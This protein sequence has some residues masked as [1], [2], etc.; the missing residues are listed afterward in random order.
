MG[1][2][3]KEDSLRYIRDLKSEV[4]YLRERGLITE[5][6]YDNLSNKVDEYLAKVN[7]APES[8]KS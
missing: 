7:A 6:E 8:K 2:M 1:E 3:S 4:D 5:E